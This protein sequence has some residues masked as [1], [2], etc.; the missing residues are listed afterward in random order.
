MQDVKGVYITLSEFMSENKLNLVNGTITGSLS[1]TENTLASLS[2]FQN[3]ENILA[4]EITRTEP[5]NLLR[6]IEVGELFQLKIELYRSSG[7]FFGNDL[8][9]LLRSSGGKYC[10][11][12]PEQNLFLI[13]EN[14]RSWEP[15]GSDYKC[16]A[17]INAYIKIISFIRLL[18]KDIANYSND[19][20]IHLFGNNENL[21]IPISY[22]AESITKQPG[23]IL[24]ALAKIDM[25]LDSERHK[26]ETFNQLKY[27]IID[28]LINVPEN[29]RFDEFLNKIGEIAK[30]FFHNHELFVSGFS[31]EDNKE[32]L[33]KENREFTDKLNNAINSIHSRIIGI[34][35]GTVLPALLIK[36]DKIGTEGFEWLIFI[37]SVFIVLIISASLYSQY[38][39]LHKVKDEYSEK[40]KRMKTEIP[41]LIRDLE[42][43]Y[44]DLNKVFSLNKALIIIVFIAL[45]G[46]SIAPVSAYLIPML[47]V[48]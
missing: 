21:D 32:K 8:E 17:S 41:D 18:K 23:D 36:S 40:W 22:C 7:C 1:A 30:R 42:S 4:I 27:V 43:E 33:K 5:P 29:K 19:E 16:S 15:E 10:G 14:W 35:I 47:C 39:L 9:D 46:F 25:I 20:K 26:N 45:I 28:A 48:L 6:S 38:H 13:N 44:N 2:F 24:D 31:F 3:F 11:F 12:V 37:S 34:P